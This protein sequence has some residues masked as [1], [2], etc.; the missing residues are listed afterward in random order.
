MLLAENFHIFLHRNIYCYMFA[1]RM[2][3]LSD[4]IME[5]KAF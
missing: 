3:E 4:P 1:I 5:P 2:I